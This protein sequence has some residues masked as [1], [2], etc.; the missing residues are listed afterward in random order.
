MTSSYVYT[1]APAANVIAAKLRYQQGD[2]LWSEQT[3][4]IYPYEFSS[5]VVEGQGPCQCILEIETAGQQIDRSPVITLRLRAERTFVK[6]ALNRASLLLFGWT[7]QRCGEKSDTA[8]GGLKSR[9]T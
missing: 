3:D 5:D 8:C 6:P 7:V 1:D 9:E 4:A 2:G